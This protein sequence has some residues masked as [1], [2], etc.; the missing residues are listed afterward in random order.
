MV[1]TENYKRGGG[2]RYLIDIVNSL[3][4]HYSDIV[5][6]SNPNGIFDSD[7]MSFRFPARFVEVG[8][9]S[10]ER[11]KDVLGP[12]AR[13]L[14]GR[15]FSPLAPVFFL[16]N[17]IR[18]FFVIRRIRPSLV[19]SCNGGY[20]AARSTLACIVASKLAGVPAYLTVVSMP[21]PRSRAMYLLEWPINRLV[22]ASA[23]GVISN[24]AAIAEDLIRFRGLPREKAHVLHNCLPEVGEV[25]LR[26]HSNLTK[27]VAIGS[28][29]RLEH[30]KGV[31]HLVTAF[32]ALSKRHS[33]IRL[34]LIGEGEDRKELE[35]HIVQHGVARSV[36]LKGFLP[37]DA[38]KA[39]KEFDIFAFPTL[40]EGFP[41][42][43]L[44]AMRA[45]LPIVASRVGGIPEAV[46]TEKEALL[47][48]PGSVEQLQLALERLILQSDLRQRLASHARQKFLTAFTE[49]AMQT[50]LRQLLR[51]PTQQDVTKLRK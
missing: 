32:A 16:L 50:K 27:E 17:L 37:G 20:P 11:L 31:F 42:V 3:G 4:S 40:W 39:L 18:L 22:W 25:D 1:F 2:N 26:S 23:R 41:Y 51:L 9:S 13:A 47:I 46:T 36:E 43:V 44:E 14:P 10:L 35:K 15:L 34:I 19:F 33:Q 8:I 48:D 30:A 24:A 6:V 7:R 45:G 28:M 21:L 49:A 12:I 38:T 5:V 29:G